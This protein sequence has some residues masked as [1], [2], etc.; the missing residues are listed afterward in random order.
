MSSAI[1]FTAG[2]TARHT[3]IATPWPTL[4]L[5]FWRAVETIK[6]L[7]EAMTIL[8][9]AEKMK[10][11]WLCSKNKFLS[12]VP[13]LDLLKSH[14]NHCPDSAI[15]IYNALDTYTLCGPMC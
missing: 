15:P 7:F 12:S 9:E 3:S 1:I 13:Y 8:H 14:F 4:A 5:A 2:L 11:F 10:I 6:G